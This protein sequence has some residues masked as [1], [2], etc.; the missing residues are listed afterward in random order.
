MAGLY[1]IRAHKTV[2][3]HVFAF[4][5]LQLHPR[6]RP[7]TDGDDIQ[8]QA[9]DKLHGCLR[10]QMVCSGQGTAPGYDNFGSCAVSLVRGQMLDQPRFIIDDK[11]SID[12]MVICRSTS[13]F[14]LLELL[15]LNPKPQAFKC[16]STIAS[17][18]V[19][20]S[21]VPI[22]VCEFGF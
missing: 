3:D 17:G 12:D 6:N 15:P 16:P 4:L 21:L 5:D 10:L 11:K 7:S 8:L 2:K 18:C 19:S 1:L 20:P 22:D 13:P 14:Q 9:G